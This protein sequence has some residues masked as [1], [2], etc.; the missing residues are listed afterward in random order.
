[1]SSLIIESSH[2]QGKV[3]KFV[4]GGLTLFFWGVWIYLMLPLMGPLMAIAGLDHSLFGSAEPGSYLKFLF[5]ILLFIGLVM[6]S[7]ELWVIYNIFLHRRGHRRESLN[8]VY[9]TQLARHFGVSP[10]E[11]ADWHRSE[12]MIVRLTKYGKIYDVEVNDAPE[13]TS[14]TQHRPAVGS[15]IKGNVKRADEVELELYNNIGQLFLDNGVSRLSSLS[16]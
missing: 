1:M 7:M 13:A 2:R 11:L 14:Q 12:Q 10:R 6:L 9:R 4:Q 3:R 5:L 8:I 16:P 15:R